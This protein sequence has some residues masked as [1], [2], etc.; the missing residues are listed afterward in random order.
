[1]EATPVEAGLEAHQPFDV[2]PMKYL[3]ASDP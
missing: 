2:L 3:P 1:M